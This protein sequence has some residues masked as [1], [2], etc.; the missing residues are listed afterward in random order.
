MNEYPHGNEQPFHQQGEQS[1]EL[2]QLDLDIAEFEGR[3]TAM[4]A[5]ISRV[6]KTSLTDEVE[7]AK[8]MANLKDQSD[9]MIDWFNLVTDDIFRQNN[10]DQATD[11]W[12]AFAEHDER[13][14]YTEINRICGEQIFEPTPENK[15]Y[16]QALLH[17]R[18]L[19][20]DIADEDFTLLD[21]PDEY[22]QGRW[23]AETYEQR[24]ELIMN[25][26]ICYATP[27]AQNAYDLEMY[28]DEYAAERPQYTDELAELRTILHENN[29][30]SLMEK[31]VTQFDGTRDRLFTLLYQL[32]EE[33]DPET[34]RQ[35]DQDIK[36]HIPEV[37]KSFRGV[38]D[39]IFASPDQLDA[40]KLWQDFYKTDEIE[41]ILH[42]AS[43]ST[44]VK[45][46]TTDKA[47]VQEYAEMYIWN[48]DTVI[49][50]YQNILHSRA[51][52]K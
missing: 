14:H 37:A 22:K 44:T 23:G 6:I 1:N 50:D 31:A 10:L 27:Q 30:P 9:E 32:S 36:D 28:E 16:A 45:L 20:H 41:Q 43:I 11:A 4:Y 25:E 7:L 35:L 34:C 2:T 12:V 19:G 5:T 47:V 8:A 17:A 49:A 39:T 40:Q 52:I 29:E 26:L 15:L 38:S 24:I 48:S 3:R 51:R 21:A 33:D 18:R 13:V 46:P 42:A